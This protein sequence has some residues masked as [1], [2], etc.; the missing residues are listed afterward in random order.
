M[1]NPAPTPFVCAQ[2]GN[3][4]RGEGYVRIDPE[5]ANRIASHLGISISKFKAQYTRPPEAGVK[6][7][8]DDLW[9]LDKPGP[10]MECIFLE[11]N[12]CIIHEA[13]PVQCIG[14]PLR[15]RTP[16]VLDYC[17]GMQS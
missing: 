3:C 7:E 9:L 6:A 1:T 13:K 10:E 8:P 14:F 17:V 11:N 4:C 15:W 16:D 2:C 5:D 12:Q